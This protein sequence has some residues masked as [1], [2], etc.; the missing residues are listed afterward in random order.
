MTKILN[1]EM[2]MQYKGDEIPIRIDRP[3]RESDVIVVLG[4]GYYNDM[5]D[6]LLQFLAS[7]LPAE[8]LVVVR[9]NYPFAGKRWKGLPNPKKWVPLYQEV[10]NHVQQASF[11]PE[12]ACFFTGGKSLSSLVSA[13]MPEESDT[14]KIF[15]GAP[16]E[17]RKGFI[18]WPVNPEPFIRQTVPMI[19][20]QG[21]DDP[22]SPRQ[23]LE[24]LM[25]RLNPRGHFLLIPGADH[26]LKI[27]DEKERTQKEVFQEIS[28]IILWFVSESLR[29]RFETN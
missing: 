6:P 5:D 12:N 14:G 28:D 21:G 16:L 18:H 26:S 17:F 9:F 4:H 8:R 13:R 24:L 22:F 10:I 11:I 2:T 3:E 15:L 29:K 1:E 20:I 27:R 19:F 23:K 25:G 7:S